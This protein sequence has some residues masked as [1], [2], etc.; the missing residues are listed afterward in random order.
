MRKR[1]ENRVG[2]RKCCD[3]QE[4][5]VIGGGEG[6]LTGALARCTFLPRPPPELKEKHC[7]F[8]ASEGI[9]GGPVGD[10]CSRA[11]YV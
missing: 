10:A 1:N 4:K 8:N 9:R 7:F 3:L 5:V 6:V 11:Y 2:E